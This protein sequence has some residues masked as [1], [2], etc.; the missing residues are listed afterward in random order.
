MVGEIPQGQR[1]LESL[2]MDRDDTIFFQR[3]EDEIK[4]V[5][6]RQDTMQKSL[7]LLYEDR[8]I[9]EDLVNKMNSLSE[10]VSRIR[11]RYDKNTAEIKQEM[12]ENKEHFA[13]KVEEAGEQISDRL[14]EVV[15]TLAGKRIIEIRPGFIKRIRAKL[16]I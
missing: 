11:E 9:L 15:D 1:G 10:A 6:R 4:K 2:T 5:V 12:T 8:N 13:I 14:G 7:D 16:K 3:L